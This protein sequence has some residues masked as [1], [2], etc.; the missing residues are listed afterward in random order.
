MHTSGSTC[1]K[2]LLTDDI[3]RRAQIDSIDWS[4]EK[5]NDFGYILNYQDHL[6]KLIILR[7]LRR[8]TAQEVAY[9]LLDIFCLMGAPN[10]IQVCKAVATNCH[11]TM[12]CRSNPVTPDMYFSYLDCNVLFRYESSARYIS[13]KNRGA[14]CRKYRDF[15]AHCRCW[16]VNASL[17]GGIIFTGWI[18][19]N[20]VGTI[21]IHLNFN[22]IL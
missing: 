11:S 7:P 15:K 19:F 13:V 1:D 8:K 16:L 22:P 4:S 5:S 21:C 18:G 12:N 20:E 17:I 10:I 2:N 14:I 6:T 9:H 3:N